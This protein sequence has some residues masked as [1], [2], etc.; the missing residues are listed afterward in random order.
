MSLELETST[1]VA[2]DTAT[3]SPPPCSNKVTH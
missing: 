2:E 1:P 3:T